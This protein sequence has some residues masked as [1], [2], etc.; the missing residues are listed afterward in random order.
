MTDHADIDHTG[1]TGVGGG[2][3]SSGTSFPGSPSNNDLFYRTDRDLLYFY[4]GSIWLTVNKYIAP[5][6]YA[7]QLPSWST[8]PVVIGRISAVNGHTMYLETVDITAFVSTTNTGSAYWTIDL[9]R[10]DSANT[11]TSIASVNTSADAASTW[12]QKQISV[13]AELAS[14]ALHLR[15]SA[16]KTGSPGNMHAPCSL[17]YRLKG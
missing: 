3:I 7:E 2:G 12:I 1:L 9:L 4:N 10:V 5:F 16:T 11:A 13:N 8:S 17:V 6:P 15:L 14:G